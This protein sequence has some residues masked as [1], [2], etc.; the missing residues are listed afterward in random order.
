[1]PKISKR[2]AQSRKANQIS[3]NIRQ[4][5]KIICDINKV[6]TQM[7]DDELQLIYKYIIQ[8]TKANN[9]NNKMETN[10]NEME[11]NNNKMEIN[12]NKMETNNNEMEINYKV[13]INNNEIEIN[14]NSKKVA[15]NTCRQKL[16]KIIKELPDS[17]LKP[18]A[19]LLN[20]MQYS[21]GPNKGNLLSPFLQNK[22]LNFINN[23]FYKAG[24]DLDSLIQ[25]NKALQKQV[26]Q[27]E[28]SNV[29]KNHKVKQLIGTLSQYKRKQHQHISKVRAA[30]RKPLLANSQSLKESIK[31]IIMKN[32]HHYT[33]NFINMATQVSQI[34]QMS[35]H[36]TAQ[37]IQ[38]ILGFLTGES[39][40]LPISSQ[41]IIRWN[42]EISEIHVNQ[43]FSQNTFSEYFTF[44]IMLDESTRG[45]HKIFVLCV[46]FWNSKNNKPDFQVLEMKDLATCTGKSVAQ[47]ICDIFNHF[48]INS[49]QCFVCVSDN[50][51]YMSG[52]SGGAIS[53]FNKLSGANLFRIPCGL[54]VAHIIMNNFEEIAFGKLPNVSG[55]SQKELPANLLYLA[56]DLHNG[57]D[58]TDKD[59]PMGI[60]SDYIC[61]LY[62]ER[63]KY[64]LTKYQQPIRSRWLYELI[65]AKQYLERRDI[66]IKFTEWFLS[67][68]KGR[69]KTPKAY[70]KKWE[71]FQ[72]WLHD[73]VLNIQIKL[74][75][76][77]GNDFYY[78]MVKFL[79]GYDS[80]LQIP[81]Q[82]S[83]PI[84][85]L[86][87]RRGHQMH[88]FILRTTMKLRNIVEDP[89][90]FFK[91]E[92]LEGTDL[93]NDYQM[94]QIILDLERGSQKA[95]ELHQKWLNCWLHLPLSIC[96]LGGKY[97]Q[98]FARSFAHIVLGTPL[99]S[100][101]SLREICYMKFIELDIECGKFND[102]GLSDAL[103]DPIF[104]YEFHQFFQEQIPLNQL[105]KVFEF[106][107]N[108]IWYIVVH[109][110][111]VE[112]L[113]NKWDIKTHPNMTSNLQQSKLRLTS[114]PHNEIGCNSSD[115]MELRAKKIK[116]CQEQT[117][118]AYEQNLTKEDFNDSECEKKANILF[119]NLFGT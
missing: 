54:H 112:G 32:K 47:A 4:Q 75:V 62:E 82:D 29:K 67:C 77:F 114:V 115:L 92:L 113:F 52:K 102:F 57:Y 24:Q 118:S 96:C 36:D 105:P 43:I 10:N 103:K 60:R 56:W 88:D 44:G 17:Q 42:K 116:K 7:N 104:N 99:L 94:N 108:R 93:L 106:V 38:L 37:T 20:I 50:T 13:E 49:Q 80:E 66:H 87:G 16:M 109:Q 84:N 22:A 98:D 31:A 71:L 119:E 2:K 3:V 39:T 15:T 101:P 97:G 111:Q 117:K 25:N 58:R 59:K 1:M 74:L 83:M 48:K 85:L 70:I 46:I 61:R 64:Q 65:C 33:T 63:F 68:L 53:L 76:R 89:Y 86:P 40:P 110:Q 41:S 79:T 91:S 100:V 30:A 8:S 73:P 45:Q 18:A 95:L 5:K 107:K 21:K 78:P 23:S 12:D 34:G 55:F 19:N 69:K 35:F 27:L 6:I 9:N 51:N 81:V 11:T 28:H 26:I 14:D 72:K 90:F